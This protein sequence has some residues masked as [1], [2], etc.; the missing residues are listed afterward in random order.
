MSWLGGFR[1]FRFSD[2]FLYSAYDI[3]DDDINYQIKT[4]NNLFGF[5]FGN[6]LDYCL[7]R[8]W[9][10]YAGPKM[11]IYANSMTSRQH[12]GN[13]NGCAFIDNPLSPYDGEQFDLYSRRTSIAFLG[14]LDFGSTFRVCNCWSVSA[15]YRMVALSGVAMTTNQIPQSFGDLAA[16]AKI[17][18]NGSLLLHGAYVNVNYN[19]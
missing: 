11:G 12:I 16:V 1:F 9:S 8:C 14:E 17:H 10:V 4:V 3:N 15:G 13:D 5:Q 2:S 6:R 19:W 7:T 18:N